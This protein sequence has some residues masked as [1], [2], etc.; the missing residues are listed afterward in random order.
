MLENGDV[1]GRY[2]K[3]RQVASKASAVAVQAPVKIDES[4]NHNL[5]F[6]TCAYDPWTLSTA[7]RQRG[8]ARMV[9]GTE[10]PGS[11]SAIVNP[12]TG[13]PADDILATIDTFDFVDKKQQ[14]DVVHYNAQR[15][16][17]LLV[18]KNVL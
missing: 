3:L 4:L 14:R 8:A 13:K 11:G 18:R 15:V 1:S 17:P 6:D 16:F 12:L 9:F 2:P 10:S 7:I 5:F